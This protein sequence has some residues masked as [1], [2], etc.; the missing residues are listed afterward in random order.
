MHFVQRTHNDM[1]IFGEIYSHMVQQKAGELATMNYTLTN[2][3]KQP[4]H[5]NAL[6]YTHNGL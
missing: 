5:S 6:T 2:K 3:A 4:V 1:D